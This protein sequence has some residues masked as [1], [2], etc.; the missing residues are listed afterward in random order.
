MLSSNS[1]DKTYL[2]KEGQ[3]CPEKVNRPNKNTNKLTRVVVVV[4]MWQLLL[5][6]LRQLIAVKSAITRVLRRGLNQVTFYSK[7][8]LLQTAILTCF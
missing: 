5:V 8:T 3:Q 7:T 1:Y 6:L 4:I 2:K